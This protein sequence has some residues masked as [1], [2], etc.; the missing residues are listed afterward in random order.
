MLKKLEIIDMQSISVFLDIAKDADFLSKN[1]D[2]SRTK[3]VCHVIFIL[4]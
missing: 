3:G 4:F 2:V 1:S